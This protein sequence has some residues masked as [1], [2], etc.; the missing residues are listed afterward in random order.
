MSE[1]TGS[2]K[3]WER[4]KGESDKAYA[5]FLIFLHL[6]SDRSL[7][8]AY[9]QRTGKEAAKA[10]DGSTTSW[11]VKYHWTERAAAWDDHLAG[12]ARRQLETQTQA[13]V[14]EWLEAR[15]RALESALDHGNELLQQARY[16]AGFPVVERTV[17]DNGRTTIFT[18]VEPKLLVA[19]SRIMEVGQRIVFDAIDR[20]LRGYGAE[21]SG[22][23]KS[24][25]VDASPAGLRPEQVAQV[26]RELAAFERQ[27]R[28]AAAAFLAMPPPAPPAPVPGGN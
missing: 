2:P 10:A 27:Q 3:P 15:D 22:P 20:A 6:G 24:S 16:L 11:S 8:K 12:L 23:A 26:E 9:K 18:A 4:R 7:L 21:E 25:T 19:A 28:E 14:A 1:T 17:K 13:N 5:A